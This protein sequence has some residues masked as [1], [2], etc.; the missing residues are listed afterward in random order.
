MRQDDNIVN[1][2][3]RLVQKLNEGKIYKL[4]G[5]YL[6]PVKVE[7]ERMKKHC[8]ESHNGR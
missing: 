7:I 5:E 2:A 1:C 6:K 4:N 3:K 8:A